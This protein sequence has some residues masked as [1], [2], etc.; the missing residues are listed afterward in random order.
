[1]TV[2][3]PAR[4]RER[5]SSSQAVRAV[6]AVVA[7]AGSFLLLAAGSAVSGCL[8][9]PVASE[10]ASAAQGAEGASSSQDSTAGGALPD[11][12]VE[13]LFD[14]EGF[15]DV[16]VSD[17]EDVVGFLS[18]DAA[19]KAFR[20]VRGR[21]EASGW[22]FVESGLANAASFAKSGGAYQACFLSCTEVAGMTAV[23]V[24]C[25]HVGA[26]SAVTE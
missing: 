6:R 8:P 11:G 21:L 26:G 7:V 4:R 14:V 17:G 24:Q 9:G 1:M 23:V 20:D 12:F 13:E 19:E 10:V 3:H 22:T 25:P 16:R 5:G 18:H 2:R 15:E